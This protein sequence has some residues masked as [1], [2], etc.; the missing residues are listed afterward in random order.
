MN[1]Y[2]ALNRAY[3]RTFCVDAVIVSIAILIPVFSH[4][5]FPIYQ[6]SPI[7]FL[8]MLSIPYNSK[9]WNT[10]ILA[11]LIPI[12]TYMITGMPTLTKTICMVIEYNIVLSVYF[13]LKD[14]LTTQNIVAMFVIMLFAILIGK[15]SYYISKTILL[16]EIIIDTPFITQLISCVLISLSSS[17]FIKFK[18]K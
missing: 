1:S 11:T 9:Q 18:T 6:F 5:T 10:H 13:L 3:I 8:L 12:F 4:L 17:V 2:D 14:K 7:L 16:G 15:C